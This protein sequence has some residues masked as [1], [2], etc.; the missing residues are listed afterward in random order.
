MHILAIFGRQPLRICLAYIK[1]REVWLSSTKWTVQY[2]S[3]IKVWILLTLL[4][5]CTFFLF[6][7][8]FEIVGEWNQIARSTHRFHIENMACLAVVWNFL[9]VQFYCVAAAEATFENKKVCFEVRSAFLFSISNSAVS[10]IFTDNTT[11]ELTVSHRYIIDLLALSLS[12]W[13]KD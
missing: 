8:L 5:C 11:I 2:F 9:F 1:S 10:H 6:R 13:P 3:R 12:K 4:C 7:S